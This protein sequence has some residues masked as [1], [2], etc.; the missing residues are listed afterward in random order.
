MEK[1]V[2]LFA[3]NVDSNDTHNLKALRREYSRL[4]DVTEKRDMA[5]SNL[6]WE[7]FEQGAV[8]SA[9]FSLSVRERGASRESLYTGRIDIQ[10]KKVGEVPKITK[11]YYSYNN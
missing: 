6:S 5:F 7:R 2:A 3:Q 9:G 11:M 10:V 4:F 1:F 8:G